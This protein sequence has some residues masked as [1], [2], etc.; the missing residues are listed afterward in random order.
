M[1]VSVMRFTTRAQ[2]IW[3]QW[4]ED[5]QRIFWK[6][7]MMPVNSSN[8]IFKIDFSEQNLQF[9]L[10][11]F[12]TQFVIANKDWI[13]CTVRQTSFHWKSVV[14]QGIKFSEFYAYA[15][16]FPLRSMY[17]CVQSIQSNSQSCTVHSWQWNTVSPAWVIALP[18][19]TISMRCTKMKGRERGSERKRWKLIF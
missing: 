4:N 6:S 11:I 7:L 12:Q 9:S 15:I 2:S 8:S 10:P 16:F 19:L 17:L 14:A 13:F 1:C 5:F 3:I 18:L